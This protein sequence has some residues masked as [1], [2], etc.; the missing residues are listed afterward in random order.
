MKK[1]TTAVIVF[2]WTL[3]FFGGYS[4]MAQFVAFGS[5]AIYAFGVVVGIGLFYIGTLIHNYNDRRINSDT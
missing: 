3:V 2:V 1:S 5:L 4:V